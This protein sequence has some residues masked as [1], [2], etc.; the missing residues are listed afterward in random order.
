ML[1]NW[2]QTGIEFQH[3]LDAAIETVPDLE[4]AIRIAS[5]HAL[6]APVSLHDDLLSVAILA[7]LEAKAV[8]GVTD[9][10]T[11]ITN[12][13]NNACT[14][15]IRNEYPTIQTTRTRYNRS[16]RYPNGRPEIKVIQSSNDNASTPN[17]TLLDLWDMILGV[18]ETQFERDLIH[19]WSQSYKNK[20]I[21]KKL[22]VHEYV[23]RDTRI[24][25]HNRF[26]LKE[27]E[28]A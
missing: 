20:E 8:T 10:T 11:F 18:A 7:F 13:V 26:K 25:L 12:K 28:L 15:F 9:M 14:E 6:Q 16:K 23:V 21:A 4:L 24:M 5:L 3:N 2:Q 17:D 1:I 27:A 19:Y 22:K